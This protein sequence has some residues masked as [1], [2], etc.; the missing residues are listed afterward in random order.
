[1]A[2]KAK[3]LTVTELL[4]QIAEKD[5]ENARLQAEKSALEAEKIV[6]AGPVALAKYND[7]TTSTTS[8]GEQVDIVTACVTIWGREP[9]QLIEGLQTPNTF[10][11]VIVESV[12]GSRVRK[13]AAW[14]P[15]AG[16]KSD[17]K[18]RTMIQIPREFVVTV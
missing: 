4:A 6:N 11:A 10:Q 5:A 13:Y 9:K 7:V 15:A 2:Q 3:E 14:I 16:I 1:M 12:R 18:P 8:D 17:E